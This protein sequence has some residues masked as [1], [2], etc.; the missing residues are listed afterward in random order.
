[1]V[2]AAGIDEGEEDTVDSRAGR[3]AHAAKFNDVF[4]HPAA[5]VEYMARDNS[6][7]DKVV[8]TKDALEADWR[9]PDEKTGTSLTS[10]PKDDRGNVKV[11]MLF[12]GCPISKQPSDLINLPKPS[13]EEAKS[14]RERVDALTDEEAENAAMEKLV[15]AQ[16]CTYKCFYRGCQQ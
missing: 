1:M 3:A 15:A 6:G 12:S 2:V 13:K 8:H 14:E 16:P 11:P 9:K 4:P 10:L 5:S 7:Y